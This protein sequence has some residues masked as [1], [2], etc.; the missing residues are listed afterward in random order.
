MSVINA[1]WLAHGCLKVGH[2]PSDQ[3]PGIS[4]RAGIS[5]MYGGMQFRI[6]GWPQRGFRDTLWWSESRIPHRYGAAYMLKL[7]NSRG[8]ALHVGINVEKG[9]EERDVAL[10]R[11]KELNEP[12]DQLLLTKD[13][14][15]HRAMRSFPEV[16]VTIQEA[17]RKLGRNLFYWVEFGSGDDT[18]HFLVTPEALY[19]RGGFKPVSWESVREFAV[20]PRRRKWGRLAIMRAFSI[21]ECTPQL[22]DSAVL[23]VFRALRD[24]RD[25][26]RGLV[27]ESGKGTA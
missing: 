10:R 14:D 6:R 9:Y 15:W 4:L 20:Q 2:L 19:I 27:M 7:D 12:V 5:A 23:E 22:D 21:D 18:Q 3:R 16:G 25:V 17:A 24:V 13:W 1:E 26:W 11:A 8:P